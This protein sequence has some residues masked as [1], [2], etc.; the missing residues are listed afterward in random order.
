MW[1]ARRR[2]VIRNLVRRVKLSN[3][4]YCYRKY[5]Q[6]KRCGQGPKLSFERQ[7]TRYSM[8]FVGSQMAEREDIKLWAVQKLKQFFIAF[9]QQQSFIFLISEHKRKVNWFAR[10]VKK[11]L[12]LR[13]FQV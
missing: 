13:K 3:I 12:Y 2:V 10:M 7:W 1:Q 11:Y 4:I 9:S 5:V 8:T 6:R